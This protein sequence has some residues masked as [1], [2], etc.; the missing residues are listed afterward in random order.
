MVREITATKDILAHVRANTN[1]H[2][3]ELKNLI[4]EVSEL[5]T[6]GQSQ[7]SGA[8]SGQSG[9]L[10]AAIGNGFEHQIG[11]LIE[12]ITKCSHAIQEAVENG[13]NPEKSLKRKREEA[14]LEEFQRQKKELGRAKL[15]KQRQ[16][17]RE[18]VFHPISGQV[19]Y[20]TEW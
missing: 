11:L 9:S 8:V 3:K 7:N 15:E 19:I 5:R 4:W 2:T 18:K 6:G 1:G 14:E 10:L 12:G 13:V 17:A 16:E 20:L